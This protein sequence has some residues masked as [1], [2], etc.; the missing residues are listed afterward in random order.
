M[1]LEGVRMASDP[2]CIE[3]TKA[4]EE[5]IAEMKKQQVL[6]RGRGG[7]DKYKKHPKTRYSG[8]ES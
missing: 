5:A 8:K 1:I 6:G 3:K 4:L 7:L 2:E